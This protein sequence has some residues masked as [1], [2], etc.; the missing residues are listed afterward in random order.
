ML[1]QMNKIITEVSNPQ[2][3]DDYQGLLGVYDEI[4]NKQGDIHPELRSALTPLLSIS[5]NHFRNQQ[6]LANTLFRRSGITFTVYSDERGTEKI[7]PFDLIPRVISASKWERLE[8]GLCQ[9]LLALNAFLHDI[10]H[11]KKIVKANLIPEEIIY[12][13]K[14]YLREVEG[15]SPPGNI[16]IHV[17]GIDLVKN[18]KGEFLVLEDNLRSPSGV[19]YVLENRFIMKRIFPEAFTK[20]RVKAVDEY[21]FRLYH[22]LNSL[23][24]K[25]D[26]PGL[27][28]VLTP[29]QYNSAY[30]EHSFLARKMG[31]YLVKGEDLWVDNKHVYLKTTHGA[32]RVAVIYRRVDDEFL[33][34]EVFNPESFLGVPGLMQAYSAGNVVVANAVGNGVADDKAI[35]PYVPNM[36]RF[37]LSEEPILE[38]IPT[39]G[40]ANPKECEYVIKNIEKMVVKSVDL[41]GG[42]GMLFGAQSSKKQIQEFIQKIKAN[43]RYYIAQPL[44][45]LSTCPTFL[46]KEIT[47]C[48]VDLRPYVIMGRNPWALPGGLTRVAL[49][50]GSYVVNSSQG[51]GSKD[52]WVMEDE[53]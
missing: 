6:H 5:K 28:V 41:S 53:Q 40:C 44:I 43:P 10:Y 16:Y 17:A 22:A 39:Y 9:R 51:G 1:F 30:F 36:I 37:Y 38:Q 11:E 21:P 24:S 4:F 42:Y 31:C 45:E 29:G 3:F 13:S 50:K 52:T 15:I 12:S 33:D 46:G 48:R 26:N 7:F 49:S 8:R 25:S 47:P 2:L 27:T 18:Q 20:T 32:E 19:S 23:R 35:Y 34:P 14:G